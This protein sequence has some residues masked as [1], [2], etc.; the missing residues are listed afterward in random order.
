[1]FLLAKRWNDSIDP[2][3]W[4]LSEKIDGYRAMWNGRGFLSRSGNTIKAPAW[5]IKGLPFEALDGEL[6]AGRDG[7][8]KV[9]SA[10]KGSRDMDWHSVKYCV[11][12]APDYLQPFEQRIQYARMILQKAE[13]ATVIKFW[14]CTG[15]KD[16]LTSLDKVVEAGGEGL[17]LRRPGSRYERKRSNTLLK[18]KKK[19]DAE[20]V[21]IGHVEGTRPGLCGSLKV[22]TKDGKQFKVASGMTEEMA[23]NPPPIGTIITY[24]WELLTNEGIPRPATFVRVRNI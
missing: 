7:F 9:A 17:M 18:L 10:V 2:T 21:V 13:H 5:F 12:D 4:I 16:L 23:R 3:G 15:K 11:F 20:A 22:M 6:Y 14:V 19:H 24:E 1:M 8:P